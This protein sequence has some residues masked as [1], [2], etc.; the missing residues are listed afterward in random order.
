[1]YVVFNYLLF[2]SISMYKGLGIQ[3]KETALKKL[4]FVRQSDNFA[5]VIATAE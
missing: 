4:L 1:M 5:A 3:T 2:L